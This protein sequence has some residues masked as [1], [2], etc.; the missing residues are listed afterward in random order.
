MQPGP[1]EENDSVNIQSQ[2]HHLAFEE[3]DCVI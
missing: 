1:G 3:F 2:K